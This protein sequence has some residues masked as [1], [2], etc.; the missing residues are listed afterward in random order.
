MRFEFSFGF[1]AK[2]FMIF[3][4]TMDGSTIKILCKYEKKYGLMIIDELIGLNHCV[5]FKW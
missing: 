1:V 4:V 3:N 2:K 5:P